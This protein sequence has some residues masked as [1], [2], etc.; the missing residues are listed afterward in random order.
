VLGVDATRPRGARHGRLARGAARPEALR[1]NALSRQR[2][3]LSGMSETVNR[4]LA[5]RAQKLD[6]QREN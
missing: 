5:K 6:Q 1:V 4:I 3:G 2:A